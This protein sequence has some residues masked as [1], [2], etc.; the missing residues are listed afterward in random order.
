MKTKSIL[1]IGFG[2]AFILLLVLSATTLI[3][4][5][6]NVSSI[7]QIVN[8]DNN[9]LKL[10]M[11]MRNAA[12]ERTINLQKMLITKD[13][14]VQDEAWMKFNAS[15]SEFVQA[16]ME[17]LQ[18]NLS[19][20][21][22]ALL[23]T[24]G[25]MS[26][27]IAPLQ[28]RIAE[29]I[30]DGASTDGYRKAK[31]LLFY[32]AI[33][34]QDRVFDVLA[35]MSKIQSTNA[36]N[37]VMGARRDYTW[38]VSIVLVFTFTV[39]ALFIFIAL[40]TVHKTSFAEQRFRIEKD[41]AETTLY[42]IADGVITTDA[43]AFVTHMNQVAQDY[44]GWEFD[45]AV[46]KPIRQ[47]CV[48]TGERDRNQT[49]TLVDSVLEKKLPVHLNKYLFLRRKDQSKFAVEGSIAPIGTE[50]NDITGTVL[51]LRDVSRRIDAENELR[52]YKE[53]LE[54]LV[55]ER[56]KALLEANKNLETFSYS[57][58]NDLR[59]PLRGINGF[60]HALMEDYGDKFDE[61]GKN[62]LVR[63]VNGTERI[64]HLL[65]DLLELS[66][67]SSGEINKDR[68]D[69]SSIATEIITLLEE[70]Q[71]TRNINWKISPGM[72]DHADESLMWVLL[73]NLIENAWKYTSR[74]S[75]ASIEFSSIKEGQQ[76]IYYV[77]DN[78]VGF[79]MSYYNK[80]F[81]T[82][83]RLDQDIRYEGTGVGLATV[84]KI[85][86]R[87][88]GK[89]WADGAL[90]KGATFYFTLDNIYQESVE[91]KKQSTVV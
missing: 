86:Q 22:K 35:M 27:E 84:K 26:A 7:E 77:K 44:T 56:T 64:G 19:R 48:V 23:K 20:E 62:Y 46:G 10:I 18:S 12:R 49:S 75:V 89:I 11:R 91:Q 50:N 6:K 66:R 43:K 39:A 87:H 58:S 47:V 28:V 54:S 88:G 24:Q 1:I 5:N 37:I 90:N 83:E 85:V 15:G 4:I 21:E 33:P 2:S 59:A 45:Q 60:S 14:F 67:V 25:N 42:S 52:S 53:N 3:I 17:L 40:Y 65:D 9:K 82:F 73:E 34:D 72:I 32:R 16:R 68:I 38:A 79:D 13:I 57:I 41:I 30:L 76:V 36:S 55:E 78:G 8:S 31:K 70:K 29:M 74:Q 63:I 80:L 81:G 51:V 71:H 69:L 61:Q